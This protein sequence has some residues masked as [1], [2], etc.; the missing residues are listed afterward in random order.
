[1][2]LGQK[3][4]I[5]TEIPNGLHNARDNIINLDA[6]IRMVGFVGEDC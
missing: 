6:I 3:F 4:V 1:M 5:Y 2:K